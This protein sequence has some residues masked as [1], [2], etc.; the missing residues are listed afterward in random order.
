[1][2][3]KVNEGIPDILVLVESKENNIF[4][5]QQKYLN[6]FFYKSENGNI[7]FF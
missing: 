2:A 5:F 6:Y 4:E 7:Y 3:F 1:M